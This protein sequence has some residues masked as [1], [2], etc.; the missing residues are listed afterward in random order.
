MNEY[1]D[2]SQNINDFFDS[3]WNIDTAVG[4]GLDIWGKIVGV[5]RNLTIPAGAANFGF[6]EGLNYQPFGQAPFYNGTVAA[7]TYTLTDSAY[8]KLILVK[9]LANISQCTA[10]S[11]NQ[12]LQN[13]FSTRGRCYVI[14]GGGMT[15]R[16]VFEFALLPYE[17]AILTQ[18]S[19]VPRPAAVNA[20]VV[21]FDSPTTFGF[22]EQGI[23][24]VNPIPPP[25]IYRNDWQGNQLLYATPRTNALKQSGALFNSPW[26]SGSAGYMGAVTSSTDIAAPDGSASPVSKVTITASSNLCVRQ[27]GLS[28]AAGQQVV[29]AWMYVPSGQPGV[30]NFR[31]AVDWNDTDVGALNVYSTFDRWVRVISVATLT[32]TRTQVDFDITQ[33][34]GNLPIGTVFYLD[35][36]QTEPGSTPTSYIPTT[37]AAVTVTDYVLSGG[38]VTL[39]VPLPSGAS[40][41]WTGSYFSQVQ[42]KNIAVSNLG[43]GAGTGAQS[44]YA[45]SGLFSGASP[46][47][48]G[49]GVFFNQS[50]GLLNAA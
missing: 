9:A 22:Q 41:N 44:I 43:F 33:S 4:F 7:S 48:F 24:P 8:R 26:I 40:L 14:D 45:L 15:M 21:Q 46:Q 17:I 13:L 12:L 32:A 27:S 49:H 28:V 5:G 30:S 31:F 23:G 42:N 16:F 10:R 39:P 19:A 38:V 18:S 34:S 50:T 6:K 20:K 36:A 3:V 37:T 47:N 25:Q 29:S 11:L 35:F 1:I 2:P